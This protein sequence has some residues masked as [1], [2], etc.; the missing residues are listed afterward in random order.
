MYVRPTHQG[1]PLTFGVT[2]KLWKDSLVMYDCEAGSYWSHV[3]GEALGGPLKGRTLKLVPALMTTWA[4]WKRLYPSG[5]VLAKGTG[6]FGPAGTSNVY[7]SY[8]EDENQLGIF[9]TRNPDKALPGK[10]FVL[11]I[12]AGGERVA[13]PFRHLSRQPLVND[14]IKGEP[15]VV[16][17]AARDATAAAFSRRAAGRTLTF[18][19]FRQH[20]GVWVMEDRETGST[21]RAF[22]GRAAAG[23]LKDARLE[24]LTGTQAFWFAWKQIYPETRLWAP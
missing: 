22:E 15:V 13:Y 18:A 23:K 4:H 10:E 20:E 17:F 5:K 2:G 14:T 21:W 6:L 9:G 8:F 11:G 16:A 24:P 3:T 1:K 12:A 7:R 19:N